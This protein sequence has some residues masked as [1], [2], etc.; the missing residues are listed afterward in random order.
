MLAE[1]DL[2]KGHSGG[3]VQTKALNLVPD[4]KAAN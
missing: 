1:L 4:Y 3:T 2:N